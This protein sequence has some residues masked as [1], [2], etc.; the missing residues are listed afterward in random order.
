M[1]REKRRAMLNAVRLVLS[2]EPGETI[3]REGAI[4]MLRKP[5]PDVEEN[6]ATL[7]QA[8]RHYVLQ[9]GIQNANAV[10]T[11]EEA[12]KLANTTVDALRAA[13][14]RGQLVKLGTMNV[15]SDGRMRRGITLVSLAGF[16]GWPLE[17]LQEAARQVAEWRKGES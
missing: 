8:Y 1:D 13:A 5:L 10:I 9:G 15:E 6:E 2:L 3:T 14:Y 17:K 16:K 11:Y 12:A 7:R 4:D